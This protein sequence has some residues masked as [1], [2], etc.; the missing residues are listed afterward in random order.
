MAHI[1]HVDGFDGIA[2]QTKP[3]SLTNK[4]SVVF[5]PSITNAP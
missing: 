4:E 5:F 1:R 2:T 3:R